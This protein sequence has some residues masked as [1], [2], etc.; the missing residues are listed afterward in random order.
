[1]ETNRVMKK[2]TGITASAFDL[3]HAGHILMLQEAKTVCDHLVVALQTD[4]TIDRPSKNKPIQTIEERFV[5]LSGCKFV[6]D[7]ITYNTEAELEAIFR[8]LDVDVR[9]IGEE[10]KDKEFTAK[11]I[12]I[13]RGIEIYY[14]S[15]KHSY[16]TTELRKRILQHESL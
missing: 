11:D 8:N 9:I 10:Y 14:N 12:C 3:L 2:K 15:R 7:I 6:D 13:E 1:M 4:P 16:S 5:Q